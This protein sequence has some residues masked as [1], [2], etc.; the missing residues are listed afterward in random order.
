MKK[1]IIKVAICLFVC[2]FVLACGPKRA[3]TRTSSDEV[4]DLSGR[5]ND[6]D[7]RLVS[8]EMIRDC[9][10]RPWLKNFKDKKQKQP[11][12]IVGHVSNKSYERISVETFTKD[13]ERSLLNSGE[14]NFVATSGQR[15]EIRS[16]RMDQAMHATEDTQKQEG[17]EAGADFIVKG[18]INSIL[19]ESG[20]QQVRFYQIELELINI[21]TNQKVW[22]GQKKLKKVIDK[23]SVS[24]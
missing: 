16:E 8:E 3:V 5:W 7:S 24:W 1:I 18:Q 15:D 23:K 4:T 22:I 13:L 2:L 19:D 14:V 12:V 21:E 11:T 10:E 20:G 9:L 17:A 6:T